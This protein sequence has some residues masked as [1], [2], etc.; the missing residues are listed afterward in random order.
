MGLE[1]AVARVFISDGAVP[2]MALPPI[3]ALSPVLALLVAPGYS[4]YAGQGGRPFI[5]YDRTLP[6][7]TQCNHACQS[8]PACGRYVFVRGNRRCYVFWCPDVPAC[9]SISLEDLLTDRKLNGQSFPGPERPAGSGSGHSSQVGS[10]PAQAQNK[11]P[12]P[13]GSRLPARGPGPA[14][15]PSGNGSVQARPP[16]NSAQT[17]GSGHMTETKASA[18]SPVMSQPPAAIGTPSAT[19]TMSPTMATMTTGPMTM[20]AMPRTTTTASTA[21]AISPHAAQPAMASSMRPGEGRASKTATDSAVGGLLSNEPLD[22][23]A[24]LAVVL[25]GLLFFI[26][27]VLL[28]LRKAYESYRKRDYTRMDY[29]INGIYSDST[30]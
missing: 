5:L 14:S 4:Q 27:G 30:L 20:T 13:P 25:F 8:I 29:L 17:Q 24:L 12:A 22:T 19:T 15:W 1:I 2:A 28:F 11:F 18:G 10:L 16:A 21:Q 3:L 26:I 6:N 7:E 9:Q 23:S